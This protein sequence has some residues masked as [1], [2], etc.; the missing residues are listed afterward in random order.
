M[1]PRRNEIVVEEDLIIAVEVALRTLQIAE[2]DMV[3]A[4][5][6]DVN[7][8]VAKMAGDLDVVELLVAIEAVIGV[9]SVIAIVETREE[10]LEAEAGVGLANLFYREYLLLL[11]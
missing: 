9:V 8:E 3:V 11:V 4:G 7:K 6:K 2:A 5:M 1:Y 10:D